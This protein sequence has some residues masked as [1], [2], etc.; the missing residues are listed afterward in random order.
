M[1]ATARTQE[2]IG[3]VVR[4]SGAAQAPAAVPEPEVAPA[5]EAVPRAVV[6]VRVARSATMRPVEAAARAGLVVPVAGDPP[7]TAIGRVAPLATT[8]GDRAHSGMAI[9]IVPPGPWT[10]PA[11]GRSAGSGSSIP[12]VRVG[13]TSEGQ[14]P[15]RFRGRLVATLGSGA[16]RGPTFFASGPGERRG[17]AALLPIVP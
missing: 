10:N 15:G 13:M 5:H 12:V 17:P 8:W 1:A 11:S 7:V 9:A 2:A 6:T 16:T 3:R 4:R 14:R